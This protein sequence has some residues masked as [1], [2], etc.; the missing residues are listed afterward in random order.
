VIG[1]I[2]GLLAREQ[3]PDALLVGLMQRK[4]IIVEAASGDGLLTAKVALAAFHP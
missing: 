4:L 2:G 3:R 1:H